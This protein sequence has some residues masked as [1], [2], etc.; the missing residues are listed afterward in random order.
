MT[1]QL[2]LYDYEE[3]VKK[4]RI[5]V[6]LVLSVCSCTG[7]VEREYYKKA[8]DL[9]G[10]GKTRESVSY[11]EKVVAID[12]KSKEGK[13]SILRL[14]ELS[15]VIGDFAGA[16]KKYK[17]YLDYSLPEDK[18]KVQGLI[19]IADI[20]DQKFGEKKQA[21]KYYNEA[22]ELI[23][24]D[25]T[26]RF[27]TLIKIGKIYYDLYQF[28]NSSEILLKAIYEYEKNIKLYDAALAQECYYYLTLSYSINSKD[29]KERFRGYGGVDQ[30]EIKKAISF[31]DKCI[32][33]NPK[34]KYGLQCQFQKADLLIDLDEY[35]QALKLLM[36]LRL[37]FPNQLIVESKIKWLEG[38]KRDVKEDEGEPE[39]DLKE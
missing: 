18:E 16:L 19:K 29:V 34:S 14:A 33:I 8:V 21:V 31:V 9:E 15:Y 13:I 10:E 39:E 4:F 7:R 25:H 23:T 35:D 38:V 5:S 22:I 1:R 28:G 3:Q 6:L 26:A 24:K 12:P 27:E 20:Y 37:S 17:L 30:T 36:V 32:D 2:P 11:Y